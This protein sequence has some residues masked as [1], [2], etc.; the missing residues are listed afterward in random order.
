MTTLFHLA[1]PLDPG[2]RSAFLKA[3]AAE[4]GKEP[5]IGDGSVYRVGRA[6]QRQFLQ[7]GM[8]ALGRAQREVWWPA[9]DVLAR[10]HS[11]QPQTW[12][13]FAQ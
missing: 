2:L 6:V 1:Q 13:S 10:D 5:A 4:L 12:V 8:T 3:V 9:I 11:A 7:T